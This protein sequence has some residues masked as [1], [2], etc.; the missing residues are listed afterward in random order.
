MKRRMAE[1]T[2]ETGSSQDSRMGKAIARGVVIGFP[3]C[4]VGLTLAIWLI[5]DLD[6]FESFTTALLPGIL[7][8]G[9]AGGFAGVAATMD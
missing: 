9:F 1:H 4:L 6:I 7:L 3:V 8:G 5:T 2:E